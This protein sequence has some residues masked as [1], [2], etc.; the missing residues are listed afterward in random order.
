MLVRQPRE[1]NSLELF[2]ILQEEKKDGEKFAHYVNITV[3]AVMLTDGRVF[4]VNDDPPTT[5]RERPF[6][7]LT[8]LHLTKEQW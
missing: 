2:T 3:P 5:N 7:E 8:G 1:I 4:V 6:K